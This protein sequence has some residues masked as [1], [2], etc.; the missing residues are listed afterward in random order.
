M[1]GSEELVV[2]LGLR[3]EV[4]PILSRPSLLEA[5][6]MRQLMWAQLKSACAGFQRDDTPPR[7]AADCA[8]LWHSPLSF[9]W[10]EFHKI[11]TNEL[12]KDIWDRS[13]E[14][15]RL[16]LGACVRGIEKS[17]HYHEQDRLE[18]EIQRE[19]NSSEEIQFLLGL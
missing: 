14:G 6:R 3:E 11:W 18:R 5:I 13:Q 10:E 16:C 12:T 19:R 9:V 7:S 2:D 8:L 4:I 15:K 1:A 17:A